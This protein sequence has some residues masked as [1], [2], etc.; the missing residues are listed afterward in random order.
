MFFFVGMLSE[1]FHT[2]TLAS[3]SGL[4]VLMPAFSTFFLLFTVS[5]IAVPGTSSFAGELLILLGLLKSN[6]FSCFIGCTSIVLG[7]CYSLFFFNRLA[8]GIPTANLFY[9]K[10]LSKLDISCREAFILTVLVLGNL[11]LGLFPFFYSESVHLC[12]SELVVSCCR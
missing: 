2:K 5:N 9:G 4:T 7:G 1:R 10:T 12:C 8:Y 3:V 11:S 6:V